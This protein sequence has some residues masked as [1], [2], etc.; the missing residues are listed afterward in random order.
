MQDF[1]KIGAKS[2]ATKKCCAVLR[3]SLNA[4]NPEYVAKPTQASKSLLCEHFFVL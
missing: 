2:Q 3:V 4:S 1:K